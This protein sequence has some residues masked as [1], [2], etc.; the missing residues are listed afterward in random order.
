MRII[1]VLATAAAAAGWAS[2][3][4][5]RERSTWVSQNDLDASLAECEADAVTAA[6][7]DDDHAR[8]LGY[9]SMF[10]GR[11]AEPPNPDLPWFG[12][13][14]TTHYEDDPSGLRLVDCV[15][16]WFRTKNEAYEFFSGVTARPRNVPEF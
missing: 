4:R 1:A 16:D 9:A 11:A 6:P 2:A 5:W 15:S 14:A 10:V 3:L 7:P 12:A 8:D 13:I